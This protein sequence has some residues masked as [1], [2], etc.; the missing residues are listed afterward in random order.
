MELSKEIL[1]QYLVVVAV[2]AGIMN[3]ELA[4]ALAK[5]DRNTFSELL[6]NRI[7]YLESESQI[8]NPLFSSEYYSEGIKSVSAVLGNLDYILAA[9]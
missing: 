1:R 6:Q 3:E 4:E 8:A 9:A 7:N 2:N 5:Y